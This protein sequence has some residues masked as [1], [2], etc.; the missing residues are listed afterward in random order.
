MKIRIKEGV[1]RLH[2][3]ANVVWREKE[4]DAEITEQI[5]DARIWSACEI[6]STVCDRC[7]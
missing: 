7:P 2:W 3:R 4:W 6:E 1:N 5:P